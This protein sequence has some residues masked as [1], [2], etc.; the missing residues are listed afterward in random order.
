MKKIFDKL[1]LV[2][3]KNFWGSMGTIQPE[4]GRKYLQII[5]LKKDLLPGYINVTTYEI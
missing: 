3:V 1:D 4:T 5:S 2:T